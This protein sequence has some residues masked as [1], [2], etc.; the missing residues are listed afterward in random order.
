MPKQSGHKRLA[1]TGEAYVNRS[2][3]FCHAWLTHSTPCSADGTL[4]ADVLLIV[5]EFAE[6]FLR[7]SACNGAVVS[8]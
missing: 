6:S 1:P 4:A 5:A 8:R 7:E 2:F 3:V